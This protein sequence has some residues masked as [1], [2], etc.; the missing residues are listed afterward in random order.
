MTSQCLN[1]VLP[2]TIV[3]MTVVSMAIDEALVS[4]NYYICDTITINYYILTLN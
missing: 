3:S 4:M 1:P 2:E